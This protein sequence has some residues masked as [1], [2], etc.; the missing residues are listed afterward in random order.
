MT[1]SIRDELARLTLEL[2]SIPSET[3][4]EAQIA[5]WVQARCAAAAGPHA[6]TRL[7]NSV[8]CEPFGRDE[9]PGQPTIALVGHTDT[10]KCA[11]EQPYEIRDG[12]VYGCGA[13]DMKAGIAVMLAL[14][15]RWRE[16]EHGRPVW[17]F[18]DGEEGPAHGNGLGPVLASGALPAIDFAFI[19]EPT[20]RGVQPGCMGLIHATVTIPGV[21]AHS[22]RPWQGQNALYNAIPFLQK[23][24][25]WGRREVR[26]GDLSFYE[27]IVATAA[28]THNSR[29]VVPDALDLNVNFRF[30]PGNT[31]ESA[32]AELR[33]LAGP[34]CIVTVTD[35][36]P[37]GDVYADHP[38]IADWCRREQLAV[39]PK[40]AWTDV[41]RFT[42]NGIPAV[43]FGPGET[44]QAHQAGE[45]A[46]IDSLEHCYGALRRWFAQ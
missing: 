5:S 21:R 19:L 17:I 11:E 26:F 23:L 2:C 36:A 42:T 7:G 31:A 29:N 43:N 24:R 14:L 6:V 25:D 32:E 3:C 18:Y 40:Q 37:A 1:E 10:V 22:A 44:G 28:A 27:V 9:R 39:L 20:D 45:W 15:D 41:A 13:S 38:L 34:E 4:H 16:L 30:A 46:S 33:A 8:L 12:R 35:T